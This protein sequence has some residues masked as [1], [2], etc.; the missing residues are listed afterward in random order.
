MIQVAAQ[1]GQ[2]IADLLRGTGEGEVFQR[3]YAAKCAEKLLGKKPD[4]RIVITAPRRSGKTT[5]LLKYAE[6]NHPNGQFIIVCLNHDVQQEIGRLYWEIMGK[7]SV[8]PTPPLMLTPGNLA[9]TRG[10][11]NPIFVDEWDALPLETRNTILQ[12]GLFRAAV[13]S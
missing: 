12:T 7:Q 3:L 5:E 6:E 11:R 4:S 1:T 8:G 2:E 10:Q 13:T 9:S